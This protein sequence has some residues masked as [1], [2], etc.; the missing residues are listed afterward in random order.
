MIADSTQRQQTAIT[1]LVQF[2]DIIPI[3]Q[4]SGVLKLLTEVVSN[5]K[6]YGPDLSCLAMRSVARF[7]DVISKDQVVPIL[8]ALLYHAHYGLG[9]NEV[10]AASINCLAQINDIIPLNLRTLVIELLIDKLNEQNAMPLVIVGALGVL[11]EI[12][13]SLETS[14][15]VIDVLLHKVMVHHNEKLV[16][17]SLK[18]LVKLKKVVEMTGNANKVIDS[19]MSNIGEYTPPE[20]KHDGFNKALPFFAIASTSVKYDHMMIATIASLVSIV[21]ENKIEEVLGLIIDNPNVEAPSKLEL[22]SKMLTF[23]L[24]N[25]DKFVTAEDAGAGNTLSTSDTNVI[26]TDAQINL[27]KFLERPIQV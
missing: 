26:V 1:T 7:K 17:E 5:R 16:T 2:K 19:I 13:T 25:M 11:E 8:D 18:I 23:L 21:P 20:L 4:T 27:R 6:S 3:D 24:N 12:H 22:V 15:A 10:Q 14:T 9:G